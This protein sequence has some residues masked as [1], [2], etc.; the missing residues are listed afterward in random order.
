MDEEQR[1][2]YHRSLEATLVEILDLLEKHRLE[3]ELSLR[4]ASANR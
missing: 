1:E 2:Q 4:Q 3:R